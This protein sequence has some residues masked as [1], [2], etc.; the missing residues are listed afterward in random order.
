MGKPGKFWDRLANR[1]SKSPVA[2]ESAYQKKLEV[3]REYLSPDR[4]VLE[5]GCGTGSTAIVQAPFVKHIQAIDS[6]HNM[7]EIARG[8]AEQAETGNL[9]FKQSSIEEFNV[10]DETFDVVMGHSI[11]H[12]LANKEMVIAKVYNMLKPGGVFVSS[13][14]CMGSG[15]SIFKLILPIGGFFGLLPLVRFFSVDDLET[16]M[17]GAGFEIAYRWQPEKDR[18]VFLVAKKPA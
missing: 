16:A 14:T 10:A 9:S 11:L 13:T 2:D 7:L 15:F 12:L 8:K 4:V 5:F 6:S 1:Y 3:T 17:T 18:A